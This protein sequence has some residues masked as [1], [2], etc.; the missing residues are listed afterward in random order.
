MYEPSISRS[1]LVSVNRT[2]NQ[3]FRAPRALC[4]FDSLKSV[5]FLIAN[6]NYMIYDKIPAPG[7]LSCTGSRVAYRIELWSSPALTFNAQIGVKIE[8]FPIKPN[9]CRYYPMC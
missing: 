6:S 9:I 2:P 4:C 5:Y 7:F 1:L 3:D 8:P